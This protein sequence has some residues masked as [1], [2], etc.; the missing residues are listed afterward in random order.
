MKRRTTNE[1]LDLSTFP[2]PKI[3]GQRAVGWR[4]AWMLVSAF[5]FRS[6]LPWLPYG[7]KASLLR[8]F[9]AN[10]GGGL[11]IK[12]SVNI[13]YPWLLS[14]GHHVWIGEGVWIDNP[15]RVSMGSHVCIS[16][17]AYLV[18]GNHDFTSSS[19]DFFARP[20]IIADRCWIC[21]KAIL[22]PGAQLEPGTIVPLGRVWPDAA[23]GSAEG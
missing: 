7:V 21:A 20:I 11:V 2:A 14:I 10:V 3:E 15:A 13:K 8:A 17:G 19:F 1:R 5:V 23:E 4:I 9:G 22:K 18:T 12:P 6:K 16:Q